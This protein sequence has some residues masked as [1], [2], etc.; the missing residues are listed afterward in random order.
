[1]LD[2]YSWFSDLKLCFQSA[3]LRVYVIFMYF[4]YIKYNICE[5]IAKKKHNSK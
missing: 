3:N 2:H 5:A 4:I 1:M